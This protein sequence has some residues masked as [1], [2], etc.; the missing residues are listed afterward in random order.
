LIENLLPL[1]NSNCN[2]QLQ[3]QQQQQ[4]QLQQQLL[5]TGAA[6]QLSAICCDQFIKS[7]GLAQIEWDRLGLK[8]EAGPRQSLAK[9]ITEPTHLHKCLRHRLRTTATHPVP[10]TRSNCGTL[11]W[12]LSLL[13]HYTSTGLQVH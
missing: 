5:Q 3:Q 7:L 12:N 4:Q 11:P 9:I 8:D 1:Q 2:Q 13:W 10:G 6:H